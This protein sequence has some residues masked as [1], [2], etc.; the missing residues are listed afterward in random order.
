MSGLVRRSVLSIAAPGLSARTAF[1]QTKA[2]MGGH[3]PVRRQGRALDPVREG[4]GAAHRR[5]GLQVGAADAFGRWALRRRRW[6]RAGPRA[7]RAAAERQ[8]PCLATTSAPRRA[9]GSTRPCAPTWLLCANG[10]WPRRRRSRRVSAWPPDLVDVTTIDPGIKLDIWY[11]GPDNFMGIPLWPSARPPTCSVRRPRALG[12]IQKALAAKGYGLLIHDAYRPWYVTWMFWEATPPEDHAF[13][14]DPA[15]GLRHNRGCAVDLTLYDLKTGKAVEMPGRYDESSARSLRRFRGRHDGAAGASGRPAPGDGGRG[16]HR[17]SRGVVALRLQRLARYLDRDD[18]VQRSWRGRRRARPGPRR[19]SSPR[20]TEC[21]RTRTRP[22]PSTAPPA[23]S[24]VR[25]RS[26]SRTSPANHAAANRPGLAPAA[27]PGGDRDHGGIGGDPGDL[28][29]AQQGLRRRFEPG[30][31]ARL[32]HRRGGGRLA[33]ERTGTARPRRR[34]TSGWAAAGSATDRACRP[35]RRIR[36]GTAPGGS[37]QS[38]SRRSWVIVRG[39]L[40]REPGTSPASRPPSARR[41]CAGGGGR[42]TS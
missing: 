8:R 22:G 6:R 36:R 9:S 5:R 20:R 3:R 25:R 32:Q 16:P 11:A 1:G 31:M 27:G 38:T 15:E 29:G 28:E 21:C 40:H 13:V 23:P 33:P 10:P 14:A 24:A 18:D 4:R 37:P 7:G 34:R 17:L 35:A 12:R 30:R 2:E 39:T 41:S 19:R 42:R 26:G